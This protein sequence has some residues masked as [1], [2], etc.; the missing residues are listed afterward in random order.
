MFL[1][2]R[3]IKTQK[4]L[5][6]KMLETLTDKSKEVEFTVFLLRLRHM[7]REIRKNCGTVQKIIDIFLKRKF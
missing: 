1:K 4:L 2:T 5:D 3:S 7:L 6:K